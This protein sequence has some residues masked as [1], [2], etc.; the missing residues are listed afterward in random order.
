[1][2]KRLLFFLLI[3]L[4]AILCLGCGRKDKKE[5]KED[6]NIVKLYFADETGTL[7]VAKDHKKSKKENT[8]EAAT[9]MIGWMRNKSKLEDDVF[10]AIPSEVAI[11]NMSVENRILRIDF[12]IGYE[13]LDK[14]KEII[15]RAALVNTLLQLPGIDYVEFS[16]G[17]TTMMDADGVPIG[18][19][20]KQSFMFKEI[21]M[22]EEQSY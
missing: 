3:A 19:L 9:E 15:C 1:M 22:E 12:A 20:T 6:P 8:V 4:M 7:L 14:D 10:L 18:S 2:K 13:H 16:I 17:G 5:E 11:N 21:P